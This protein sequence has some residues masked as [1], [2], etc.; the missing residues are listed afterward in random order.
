MKPSLLTLFYLIFGALL[1]LTSCRCQ[2]ESDAARLADVHLRRT[3]VILK[4]LKS[5][6]STEIKLCM[7]E[8]RLLDSEFHQLKQTFDN[9]YADP[10]NRVK[11]EKAYANAMKKN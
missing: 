10:A 4:I 5:S 2:I 7:Q 11:F 6:D 1:L 3:E 8:A 9:K